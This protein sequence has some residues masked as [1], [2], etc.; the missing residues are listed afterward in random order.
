M[1]PIKEA[2]QKAGL[3]QKQLATLTGIPKRSIEDWECGRRKCSDYVTEMV[4]AKIKQKNILDNVVA[5]L[6]AVETA[7]DVLDIIGY[8]KKEG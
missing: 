5:M 7:D 6:E 2:R 4:L 3:T 1:H 8:I